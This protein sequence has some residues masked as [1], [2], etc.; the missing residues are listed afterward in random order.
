MITN[1]V[2]AL[3]LL[4]GDDEPQMLGSILPLANRPSHLQRYTAVRSS[5]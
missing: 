3:L 2:G 5:F 4:H 1:G